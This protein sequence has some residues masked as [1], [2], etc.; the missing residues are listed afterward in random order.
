MHTRVRDT[1]ERARN[2]IVLSYY[3]LYATALSLSV[4]DFCIDFR[5]RS[6]VNLPRRIATIITIPE[7]RCNNVTVAKVKKIM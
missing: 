3:R 2:N 5:D 4:I 7:T 1:R 6:P